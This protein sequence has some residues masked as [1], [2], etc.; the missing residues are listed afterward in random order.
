MVGGDLS[1]HLE[2]TGNVLG[3]HHLLRLVL[4]HEGHEIVP[5]FVRDDDLVPL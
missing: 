3:D 4:I 1:S 5:L 2:M